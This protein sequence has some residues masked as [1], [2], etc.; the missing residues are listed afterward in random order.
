MEAIRVQLRRGYLCVGRQQMAAAMT[1]TG[2]PNAKHK[3]SLLLSVVEAHL[4]L[5]GL[6]V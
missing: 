2:L 3:N 1:G 4:M 6:S 5:R